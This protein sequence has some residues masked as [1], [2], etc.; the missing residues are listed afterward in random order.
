[1]ILIYSDLMSSSIEHLFMLEETVFKILLELNLAMACSIV[2]SD[3][4]QG[5][6]NFLKYG[7]LQKGS[8]QLALRI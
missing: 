1:M 4:S 7:C 3:R 5:K 8:R 6:S 2:G